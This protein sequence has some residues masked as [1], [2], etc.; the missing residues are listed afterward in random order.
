LH[1]SQGI[2]ISSSIFGFSVDDRFTQTMVLT[3]GTFRRLA[4]G[5]ICQKL[6]MIAIMF[7]YPMLT[8]FDV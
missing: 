4:K 6:F 2:G 1:D 5:E 3:G 7:T 8:I